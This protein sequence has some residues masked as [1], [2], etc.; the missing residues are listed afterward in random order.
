MSKF[1][2]NV[3]ETKNVETPEVLGAD[4]SVDLQAPKKRGRANRILK[5]L[6]AALVS[7]LLIGAVGGYFYWRH[8][9]RTPQYSLA[10]LIDAARRDDQRTVDKLV[11]ADA[12]VDDFMPQIIEKA[13]EL[14]GRNLP[15]ATVAKARQAAAPLLPALKTRARAEIPELIRAKTQKLDRVPFWAIAL[16]ANRYVDIKPD[17]N[18][19][20][21]VGSSVPEQSGLNFTMKRSGG[22][23]QVVG[24]KDEELAKNIAE[25]IGQ[26]LIAA[27]SKGGIKKAGE[28][29]GVG[30]LDD[31]L[32]QLE[33]A[34]K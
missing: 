30:N 13:V 34:F 31:L 21:F 11:D 1:V 16:A 17:G 25:K 10:L 33:G 20:A 23:W 19:T 14:Y 4:E 29:I 28:E 7:L 22:L 9:K 2:V 6:G 8:L 15:P 5:I 12:L 32:R 27:A 3:D 26:Q 18:D 24:V